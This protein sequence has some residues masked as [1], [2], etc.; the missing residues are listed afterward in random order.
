MYVCWGQETAI[1]L[2]L[3]GF[4]QS[5]TQVQFVSKSRK[6]EIQFLEIFAKQW[7][8]FRQFRYSL[9]GKPSQKGNVRRFDLN[10]NG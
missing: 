8:V 2:H 7:C 4:R 3:S 10:A 1:P 5:S 9:H 6:F